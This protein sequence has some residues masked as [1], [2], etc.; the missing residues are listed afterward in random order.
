MTVLA[1]VS[2]DEAVTALRYVRRFE[3]ES[4]EIE[5]PVGAD[6][7]D[8]VIGNVAVESPT[9]TVTE[10]GTVAPGLLLVSDT[11]S[12]T[13]AAWL[14]ITWPKVSSPP[15]RLVCLSAIAT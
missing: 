4:F 6:T 12:G 10:D 9:A 13:T 8:V 3:I 14:K 2:R 7:A 5:T 15:C 1:L 11:T